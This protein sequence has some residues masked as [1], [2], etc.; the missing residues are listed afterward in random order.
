MCFQDLPSCSLYGCLQP[1]QHAAGHASSRQCPEVHTTCLPKKTCL[2]VL[3]T[4]V[5]LFPCLLPDPG[6]TGLPACLLTAAAAAQ[7]EE[8]LEG[9]HML[10]AVPGSL[11]S[12]PPIVPPFLPPFRSCDARITLLEAARELD[13]V[14]LHVDMDAFY[15]RWGLQGQ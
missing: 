9:L 5:F 14:W 1:A 8:L 6:R 13:K 3:Y 2:P 12:S 10:L 4:H 15:A 11:P 7:Q